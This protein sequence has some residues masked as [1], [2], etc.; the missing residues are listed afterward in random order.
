MGKKIKISKPYDCESQILNLESDYGEAVEQ[1]SAIKIT[2]KPNGY[3]EAVITI[4]Y[5]FD[6]Q[7]ER[8]PIGREYKAK[9]FEN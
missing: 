9:D 7:Q 4:K 1:L 5:V 2:N 8:L 3:I 6:A